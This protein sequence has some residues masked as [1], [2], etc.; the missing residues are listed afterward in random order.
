[1]RRGEEGFTQRSLTCL[2]TGRE[3][4][5]GGRRGRQIE[6]GVETNGKK[7]ESQRQEGGDAEGR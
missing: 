6:R 2:L 5:R 1:M 7:H 4:T 3:E